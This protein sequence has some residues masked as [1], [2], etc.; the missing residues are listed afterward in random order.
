MLDRVGDGT[1]G[2]GFGLG[3]DIIEEIMSEGLSFGVGLGEEVAG[4]DEDGRWRG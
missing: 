2:E 3:L 4:G 1:R